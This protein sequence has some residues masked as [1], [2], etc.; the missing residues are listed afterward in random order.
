MSVVHGHV[1]NIGH[2]VFLLSLIILHAQLIP[3]NVRVCD[4][5]QKRDS[6]TCQ[7]IT[8]GQ[9]NRDHLKLALC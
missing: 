6:E 5:L 3:K 7:D 1:K 9:T 2:F 4:L 8:P